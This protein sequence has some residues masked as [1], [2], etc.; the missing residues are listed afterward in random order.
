MLAPCGYRTHRQRRTDGHAMANSWSDSAGAHI[1]AAGSVPRGLPVSLA[2]DLDS[3]ET[4][5]RDA[6]ARLVC[7]PY[8]RFDAV[9]AWFATIGRTEKASPLVVTLAGADGRPAMLLPL[10]LR[11]RYGLVE[12]RLPGGK[13]TNFAAPLYRAQA[14]L[15]RRTISE[16]LIEAADRAGI[17]VFAFHHVP[18]HWNGAQNPLASLPGTIS[19][20]RAFRASLE[21]D[22][23]TTLRRMRGGT[24]LRRLR[25]KERK[26][27]E[28]GAVRF[29]AAPGVDESLRLFAVFVAQKTAW[30]RRSGLPDVFAPADARA[31]FEGMIRSG[32]FQMFALTVGE[33]VAATIGGAAHG[34]RFSTSI[35]SFDADAYGRFSPGDILLRDVIGHCAKRGMTTFDLGV[36]DAEYKR[37]WLADEEA[38]VDVAWGVGPLGSLAAGATLSFARAKRQIK[39]TPWLARYVRGV[40]G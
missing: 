38:M 39:A 12:A 35:N 37:H 20:N 9:A 11:R 26:L 21:V 31:Y 40:G 25:S 5:W 29:I 7:T 10:A 6:E 19:A 23:E 15:D 13:H 33:S 2:T 34:G 22:A 16:A 4:S 36:G 27:A 17:D 28:L 30:F 32:A 24:A 3:V 18:V 8:Q 1:S 14:V